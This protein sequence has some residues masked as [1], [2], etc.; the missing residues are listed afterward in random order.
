MRKYKLPKVLV[1]TITY[2]GKDYC[3]DD[4]KAQCERF[5][6]PNY[7]HIWIDNSKDDSY[8]KKLLSEG[9]EA[10]HV[11]RGNTSREAL[12]R[13][14]EFARKIAVKEGYDYL[15]SLESDILGVPEDII[16]RLIGRSKEVVGCYYEIGSPDYRIPCITLPNKDSIT[17]LIGTRLLEPKEKVSFLN[18][19]L[20]NVN[21]CGLGCTLIN[22]EVFESIGFFYYRDLKSHSDVFF[23]ND[24]W[25]AGYRIFVDTDIQLDHH[26]VPWSTV[27]DR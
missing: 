2:D 27:K 4:F 26:N 24:V 25:R 18:K 16:Q 15:L 14:Q 19:G 13:S 8:T 5:N 3:F 9:L 17:G 21:S 7:R 1:F 20:A 23:A 10:Y 6:Y 12:A 22:R 11:A